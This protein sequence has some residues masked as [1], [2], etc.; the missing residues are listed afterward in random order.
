MEVF[1]LFYDNHFMLLFILQKMLCFQ[2]L[3]CDIFF[4][5]A[6]Q[7]INFHWFDCA[8]QTGIYYYLF[9]YFFYIFSIETAPGTSEPTTVEAQE[10]SD[11]LADAAAGA[12]QSNQE[13]TDGG[14]AEPEVP[15]PKKW[16]MHGITKEWRKFSIDLSPRVCI[17]YTNN[18][19]LFS[20]F[21]KFGQL[22]Y[23]CE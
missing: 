6:G 20:F 16:S 22:G 2:L 7:E 18:L 19:N 15:P 8:N 5:I 23:C 17:K 10:V 4:I 3:T 12:D 11:T 13:A 9:V 14:D 1:I 21:F